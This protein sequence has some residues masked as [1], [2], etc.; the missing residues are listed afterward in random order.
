MPEERRRPM[1]S[2]R[3]RGILT[4]Q[5]RGTGIA[6]TLASVLSFKSGRVF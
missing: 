2:L 3:R 4:F 6:R 1:T 5:I